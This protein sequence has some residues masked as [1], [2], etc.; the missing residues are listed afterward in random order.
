MKRYIFRT[1]HTQK[2]DMYTY[3][4][5][6]PRGKLVKQS[7]VNKAL[8]GLYIPP[9]LDR[10]KINLN[11]RAKVLAIGYDAKDRA[12]YTYNKNYTKRQSVQKFHH[13]IQ[14][15]ESYQKILKKIQQDLYI[16]AAG[17]YCCTLYKSCYCA[18]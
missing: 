11:K 4:Y 3:K 7:I 14:F 16:H 8:E 9:A 5:T 13:M 12:Q 17:E 6:D 2:K 1:I 10:V 18:S 15:G